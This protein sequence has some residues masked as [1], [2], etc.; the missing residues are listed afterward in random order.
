VSRYIEGVVKGLPALVDEII[1][2]DDA[3]TDDTREVVLSLKESRLTV[4]SHTA[5]QGVGG[6]MVT[7]FKLALNRS[8]DVIVKVD[9]DGQMNPEYLPALLDAV[10]LEG[11]SYAKG[12]RFLDSKE[13]ARMPKVRLI[14]NFLMTFLTKL[15]SG[16]WHI[17]D[18]QNG[19]VA[20]DATALRKLQLDRLARR[21]FFENDMLIHLNISRARVKDVAI[22]AQYGNEDSSLRLGRVV[23][24]F[25][26]HLIKGFWYRIYQRHILRDFSAIAVFWIIGAALLSWGFMFGAAMWVKSIWTGHVAS[27]GTVMLSALPLILG[28]QLILQAIAIEIQDSSR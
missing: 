28:F 3:S 27:T 13:L 25:P 23:A 16:Y 17:F 24:T 7:G 18:P 9:G 4:A 5:N 10:T 22:P 21:Y 6:A 11:Y 14:G 20:V 12:N 26:I 19:F 1:V 2:V 8:C 15:A